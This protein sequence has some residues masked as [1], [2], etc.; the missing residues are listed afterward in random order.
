LSRW[1][2]A[3]ATDVGSVRQVNEDAVYGDDALIV[4]AD[5]MGGH[6]A[7]EVASGMTVKA[8]A[9]GF[10]VD[11]TI[12]GLERA[13]AQANRDVL[14]D[15]A[16]KPERQG[17]GTTAIALGLALHDGHTVPVLVHVGDSRAYQFRDGALRQLTDDHSVAEEWVRQGR[18][19]PEEAAVHPKR[20]QLTRCVGIG[21]DMPVD[22]VSVIA[23]PG[24]RLVLCSDGLSN[25]LGDEELARLAGADAP[26]SDVVTSLVA[27]ANAHGGRDNITVAVVEFDEV[28]NL[29]PVLVRT[30]STSAPRPVRPTRPTTVQAS[31]RSTW[32]TSWRVWA[33]AGLLIAA[34]V[35]AVVIL[36]W[37]TYSSVFIGDNNGVVTLYQGQPGGVL[38]FQPVAVLPTDVTIDQLRPADQ[39]RVK[40]TIAVSSET[41]GL[42]L[43]AYLHDQ[44]LAGGGTTT[45][46]TVP[47]G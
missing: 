10:A 35:A 40:A 2:F 12:E 17:M 13:F 44:W 31:R 33:S 29:T 27:A 39:E 42:H 19:T 14:A 4:V 5:G 37:Y 41:A 23:E 24:D 11:A 30:G 20:H 3:V 21:P 18:L 25:E 16:A 26:L 45:T 46:T 36:H 7:G 32:W 1:R 8:I 34:S 9:D 43:V 22:V 6:A 28:T 38:W 47:K 15:A